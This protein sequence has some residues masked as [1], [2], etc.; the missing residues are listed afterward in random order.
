MWLISTP[1]PPVRY[2]PSPG[3]AL[4][5]FFGF[6]NARSSSKIAAA[7]ASVLN[8]MFRSA[9]TGFGMSRLDS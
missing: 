5:F 1:Q 8:A 2:L 4:A 6:P 9:W 7:L 3:A